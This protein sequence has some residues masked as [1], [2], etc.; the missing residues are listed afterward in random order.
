MFH[1]RI[2]NKADHTS[3]TKRHLPGNYKERSNAHP[4]ATT[5]SL[6]Q[7]RELGISQ[8]TSQTQRQVCKGATTSCGVI[9]TFRYQRYIFTLA[10]PDDLS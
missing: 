10:F 4:H 2:I 6:E 8:A 1:T 9:T 5:G 3:K 7:G